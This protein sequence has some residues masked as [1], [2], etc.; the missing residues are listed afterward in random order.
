MNKIRPLAVFLKKYS[1]KNVPRAQIF[2]GAD[3][4]KAKRN[5]IFNDI[6]LHSVSEYAYQL[7]TP[8]QGF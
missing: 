4:K 2:G 8:A 3:G 7:L 5:C 1:L 6:Y